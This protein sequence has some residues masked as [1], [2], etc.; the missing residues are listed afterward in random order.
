MSAAPQLFTRQFWLLTAGH[1]LQALGFSSLFLLPLFLEYLGASRQQIGMIMA[2]AALSGL[3]ARPVMA[4]ALD[5]LGR[6]PTLM[7]G[8]ALLVAGMLILLLADRIG[9]VIYVHR[10]LIGLGTGT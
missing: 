9:V 10:I 5:T 2:L 6:K 7:T 3:A 4:W 1:F 8:T